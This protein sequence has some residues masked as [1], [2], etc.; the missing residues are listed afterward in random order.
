MIRWADKLAEIG[1]KALEKVRKM[2]KPTLTP[3]RHPPPQNQNQ[4]HPQKPHRHCCH[5]RLPDF[6][7]SHSQ[8]T[9]W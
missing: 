7:Q 8:R 4:S 9:E 5:L 1:R 2:A 6:L 3:A